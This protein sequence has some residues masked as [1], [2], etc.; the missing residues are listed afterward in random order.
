M[1]YSRVR[2]WT[3]NQPGTLELL[4][5]LSTTIIITIASGPEPNAYTYVQSRLKTGCGFRLIIRVVGDLLSPRFKCLT[6]LKNLRMQFSIAT[7]TLVS[8]R[9]TRVFRTGLMSLTEPRTL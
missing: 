5:I 8:V 7:T 1:T 6:F 2:N 9:N 4:P 3:Q